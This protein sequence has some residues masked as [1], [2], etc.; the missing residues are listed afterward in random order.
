MLG[1]LWGKT[2]NDRAQQ[3]LDYSASLTS[4]AAGKPFY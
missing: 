3:M 1:I 4:P 2:Q